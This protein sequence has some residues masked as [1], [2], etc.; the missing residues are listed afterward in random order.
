MRPLALLALAL[1]FLATP[2]AADD[3]DALAR[4]F[5]TWRAA[6]QPASGDDIP[7]LDRPAD[8]VPDWSAARVASRLR[9]LES[10]ESRYRALDPDS[11]PVSRRVDHRLLGSALARVRWELVVAP[12]WR[13]NPLFYVDQ[14]LGA[15]FESL[16]VP[17]P[18]DAA[19]AEGVLA[20]LASV[21]ATVDAAIVNLDDG[22]APFARLAIDA[23]ADVE[24]RLATVARELAPHFPAARAA[25]LPAAA[26]DAGAALARFR[27][28]LETV[29]PAW[30]EETA[31]GRDAYLF[32]LREVALYPFTPEELVAMGRQEWDRAVAFEAIAANRNRSRPPLALPENRDLQ[33]ATMDRD[34]VAVRRFLEREG[35]QT[36]PAWVKA[37][38]L[39]PMPAYLAPIAG[40]GV[41]NDFTGPDRLAED[42]VAW[43]DEATPE[44]G[45]FYRAYASDPRVQIAHESHG[46]YLQLV[47][48]WAHEDWLRRHYYDSGANEG[49]AFY[50]EELMLQAGL[51]DDRPRVAEVIYNFAR[52]RALRVEVDVR[53]ATGELSIAEAAEILAQRVPMDRATALD[54]AAFFASAPGQAISYQIG[55]LQILRLLADARL[56]QGEA[57]TLRAFHD[58]LW[59][60]GNVPLALQ[61]W[62]LLGDRSELDAALAPR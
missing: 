36:V 17:P 9:A 37:Y 46:H 45:Y 10:F 1:T 33:I 25:L 4:E 22:R 23:L 54:E 42:G 13:R 59:K 47:L 55:K 21:P 16:L 51:F 38:R 20:R 27:E 62:E 43:I 2:V 60:N 14:T 28:R 11:G 53:L 35:I 40:L 3:L 34:I 30:R 56:A 48:S 8:W 18:F 39:R 49:I 31:V 7:R 6:N 32:F 52:L 58:F 19:R 50:N 5:W 26:R 29:S 41:D 12:G 24:T 44:S 57:F 15:L 61:R